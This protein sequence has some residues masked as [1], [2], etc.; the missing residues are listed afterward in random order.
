MPPLFV[1][2]RLA[3]ALALADLDEAGAGEPADGAG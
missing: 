2:A 3:Q 1:V